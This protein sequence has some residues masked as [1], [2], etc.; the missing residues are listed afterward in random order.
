MIIYYALKRYIDD[1]NVEYSTM[2]YSVR[3]SL[4]MWKTWLMKWNM[5]TFS[6]KRT[7]K[8]CNKL[9]KNYNI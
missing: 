4:F 1:N 6:E 5:W 8:I 7:N 2:P 3:G 9:N